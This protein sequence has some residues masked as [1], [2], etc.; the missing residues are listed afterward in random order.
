MRGWNAKTTNGRL[1]KFTGGKYETTMQYLAMENSAKD[2]YKKIISRNDDVLKI[3]KGTG[4]SVRFIKEVK[5]HLFVNEH[6][7][8]D[9]KLSRFDPDYDIAVAWQRMINGDKIEDR[10]LL[11]LR[12]EHLERALE[13]RYNLTYKEAHDLANDK[14]NWEQEV[15]NLL[16]KGGH[17]DVDIS[18]LVGK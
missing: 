16:E 15:N 14:Y 12:H 2:Y 9:S 5:E 7:F 13:K 10:D 3:H 18:D 4:Y 11:L 17:E 1:G 8:E 6:V